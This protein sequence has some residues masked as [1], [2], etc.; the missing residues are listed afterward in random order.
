M[1]GEVHQVRDPVVQ[2]HLALI[3][4]H[5]PV[6]Q[7]RH[8]VQAVA[9]DD[10]GGAVLALGEE[11]E[12]DAAR[13]GVQIRRRFV[14]DQD[15]RVPAQGD[16]DQ[17]LLLLAPGELDEGVTAETGHV[18]PQMAGHL[19]HPRRIG[20]A[21]PGGEGQELAHR[22]AQGGRQLRHEADLGQDLFAVCAR[23]QA[24]Q[25]DQALAMVFPQQTADE[26]GLAGAV[27]A[28]EGHPV[29]PLDLQVD[30][31]EDGLAAEALDD[32]FENNHAGYKTLSR[33][34]TLKLK[35]LVGQMSTHRPQ[36]VQSAPMSVVR[37]RARPRMVTSR[38][39]GTRQM[40]RQSPS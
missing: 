40:A 29:P 1:A 24:I 10:H 17:E 18:Q 4:F 35:E 7:G 14:E 13:L 32:L 16:A 26:G 21:D 39:W 20:A 12:K 33:P 27:G 15:L 22:H 11:V 30:A 25:G 6:D 31:P 37:S 23:V 2:H 36:R 8:L 9:G 5:D 3:Q 28:D 34:L 38:T 19:R